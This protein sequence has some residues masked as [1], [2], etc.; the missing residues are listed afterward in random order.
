MAQHPNSIIVEDSHDPAPDLKS[1]V[2]DLGNERAPTGQPAATTQVKTE[3]QEPEWLPAKWKGKSEK[4]RAEMYKNLESVYGR[5]ANDL[6]QQRKITDQILLDKRARDLGIDPN[7]SVEPPKRKI[8]I[9]AA[10]LLEKPSEILER[11]LSAVKDE[12]VQSVRQE[13]SGRDA[14]TKE[15]QFLERHSDATDVVS[16]PE[17]IEFVNATPT[18]ARA[19]ALVRTTGDI[20]TADALLTEFKESRKSTQ[21]S[22]EDTVS[23]EQE[24]ARQASLEGSSS[25]AP[26]TPKKI[27]RRADLIKLKMNDPETYAELNDEI[28]RAYAENRVK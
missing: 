19:A 21:P 3:E 6:G 11:E 16:S 9:S 28:L 26:A 2:S 7:K 27:Y 1:L 15:D 24:R 25:R 4:E 14:K 8:S 22:R 23:N 17:F 5:V 13:I 18:R 10:E 12:I 20:E